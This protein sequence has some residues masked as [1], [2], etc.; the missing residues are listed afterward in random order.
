M[1][2]FEVRF[3]EGRRLKLRADGVIVSTPTG[4][5]AHAFSAGGPIIH[6][7]LGAFNMVFLC[8]LDPVR[9]LVVPDKGELSIGIDA[10]KSSVLMR[11]DGSFEREVMEGQKIV[12]RKSSKDAVFVR[13]GGGHLVRSLSRL[14]SQKK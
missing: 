8:P 3:G 7:S 13:F 4:S 6:T 2:G 5:T 12:V 1:L 10:K 9:A 14:I 11:V